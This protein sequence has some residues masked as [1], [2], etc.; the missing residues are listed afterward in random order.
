M[1]N[2]FIASAYFLRYSHAVDMDEELMESVVVPPRYFPRLIQADE[3]TYLLP[4]VDIMIH[5][6]LVIVIATQCEI[7]EVYEPMYNIY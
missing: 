2:V 1:C 5:H 6:R 3:L 7:V 4:V